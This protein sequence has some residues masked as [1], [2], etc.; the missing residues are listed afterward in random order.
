M[1]ERKIE[2]L[3]ACNGLPVYSVQDDMFRTFGRV[4]NGY[5]FSGLISYMEQKTGIPE[6]GNCYVP[7]VPE[8]EKDAVMDRLQTFLYGGMPIQIG[9][10]NGRNSSY[11]GFEYHKCSEINVAVTD[12]L[13]VLGHIW[14]MEGNTF[15]TDNAK[16]FLVEKGTAIE[17]Y[18][19]TLH[20]APCKI[21]DDGYKCIVI[22]ARGTNTEA[23]E[24]NEDDAESEIL[25]KQNKWI[26]AHPDWEP[27]RKQGAYP[28]VRGENKVLR[29]PERWT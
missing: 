10:C 16:V 7:S 2:M 25:L 13:L 6:Q 19:T 26:I 5:D 21:T 11:N 3:S 29:Y 27:L 1:D 14:E 15:H 20:L 12:F 17:M 24:C 18:Q 22:L 8:L 28:G 23:K 9:Y 4:V